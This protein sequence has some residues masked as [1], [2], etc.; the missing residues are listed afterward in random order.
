MRETG[1]P[2]FVVSDYCWRARL[3]AR[4]SARSHRSRAVSTHGLNTQRMSAVQKVWSSYVYATIL[5]QHGPTA[6]HCTKRSKDS[7]FA[8]TYSDLH[9]DTCF[10]GSNACIHHESVSKTVKVRPFLNPLVSAKKTPI[11]SAS[12][13]C[14]FPCFTLKRCILHI[15]QA[16]H[17]SKLEHNSLNLNQCPLSNIVINECP[18]FAQPVPQKR[19]S[20][21]VFQKRT[22]SSLCPLMGFI[23]HVSTCC[24]GRQPNGNLQPARMHVKQHRVLESTRPNLF[25]IGEQ[26]AQQCG[27][28]SSNSCSCNFLF[29]CCTWN[30]AGDGFPSQ[31]HL[32]HP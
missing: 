12:S 13:A 18:K 5:L 2:T 22:F 28:S 27:T 11:T 32:F 31:E 8:R 14:N 15:H 24:L 1:K 7:T 19:R 6:C 26:R 21:S 30:F 9:A 17:F 20:K 10:V 23:H 29:C 16:L 3:R 4:G 25:R